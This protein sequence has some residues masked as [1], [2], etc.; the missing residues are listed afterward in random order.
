MDTED[1][2]NAIH[3]KMRYTFEICKHFQLF[4][5][6]TSIIMMCPLPIQ[7]FIQKN[8][9]ISRWQ[10]LSD[11]PQVCFKSCEWLTIAGYVAMDLLGPFCPTCWHHYVKHVFSMVRQNGLC[12]SDSSSHTREYNSQS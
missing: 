6:E 3:A 10:C 1:A 7:M 12:K 5:T 11:Y 8:I 9:P 2:G 4:H